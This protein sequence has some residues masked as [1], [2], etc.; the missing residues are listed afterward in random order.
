[1]DKLFDTD[2]DL[3]DLSIRS[4]WSSLMNSKDEALIANLVDRV[5][6]TFTSAFSTSNIPLLSRCILLLN[7]YFLHTIEPPFPPKLSFSTYSTF[8]SSLFQLLCTE[9]LYKSNPIIISQS[10]QLLSS[11]SSTHS[12]STELYPFLTLFSTSNVEMKAVPL[13]G[14]LSFLS[15]LKSFIIFINS[16]MEFNFDSTIPAII[17]SNFL[18][19]TDPRILVKLFSIIS[20][21]GK[22]FDCTPDHVTI[23]IFD[24]LI[25]FFPID[26]DPPRDITLQGITKTFMNNELFLA[27][28]KSSNMGVLAFSYCIELF[29]L[30]EECEEN[31]FKEAIVLLIKMAENSPIVYRD[32]VEK[33][34]NS[35]VDNSGLISSLYQSHTVKSVKICQSFINDLI[36]FLRNFESTITRILFSF[37]STTTRRL[38]E[39]VGLAISRQD[40]SNSGLALKTAEREAIL[41]ILSNICRNFQSDVVLSSCLD[42]IFRIVI[43]TLSGSSGYDLN[44]IPFST[45]NDCCYLLATVMKLVVE[46]SFELKNCAKILA[47]YLV[48]ILNLIDVVIMSAY[49]EVSGVSRLGRAST[50]GKGS[51]LS[52]IG[53]LI[54]IMSRHDELSVVELILCPKY[55][56]RL[57]S[58]S[59]LDENHVIKTTATSAL[60]LIGTDECCLNKSN[61]LRELLN[62]AFDDV[63]KVMTSSTATSSE[64]F[65]SNILICSCFSS[66]LTTSNLIELI[67]Y[68]SF[69]FNSEHG[70]LFVESLAIIYQLKNTTSFDLIF[71]HY[72]ET[73]LKL[74]QSSD[75][76]KALILSRNFWSN[77]NI[78]SQNFALSTEK[79]DSFLS[80]LLNDSIYS[81]R[82]RELT[83]CF[84]LLSFSLSKISQLSTFNYSTW[85]PI[86]FKYVTSSLDQYSEIMTIYSNNFEP[87]S[88]ETLQLITPLLALNSVII[89]VNNSEFVKF[90]EKFFTE[91]LAKIDF[92][93]MSVTQ[94][95]LFLSLSF[96][97][98]SISLRNDLTPSIRKD[99]K[100]FMSNLIKLLST[101]NCPGLLV[102]IIAFLGT[103]GG[104][105]FK[106]S[107][108]NSTSS[109]L[110][111]IIIDSGAQSKREIVLSACCLASFMVK[112]GVPTSLDSVKATKLITLLISNAFGSSNSPVP[113]DDLSVLL[114]SCT[115]SIISVLYSFEGV[116]LF[117]SKVLAQLIIKSCVQIMSLVVGNSNNLNSLLSRSSFLRIKFVDFFLFCVLKCSDGTLLNDHIK[118]VVQ[119]TGVLLDDSN[120]IVR[121]KAG[122]TRHLWSLFKHK[123]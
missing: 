14:R 77:P 103:N 97:L 117:I 98:Y 95:P 56:L 104:T 6:T 90:Y 80:S 16:L 67:K 60:C 1:M 19:E 24:F 101:E 105:I 96:S 84:E 63:Y 62:S 108:I 59:V 57:V 11:Y 54:F 23:S 102:S 64:S 65:K 50:V 33:D 113:A 10:F 38:F 94:I 9:S 18:S 76:E 92:S 2:I 72:F 30:Q 69:N 4:T 99:C 68:F 28:S 12:L 20:D 49:T 100:I 39:G 42:S 25:S 116:S 87:F 91:N 71:D 123:K 36:P 83:C 37:L 58:S 48:E 85:L 93:N 111:S 118:R 27:L 44:E 43:S 13:S 34:Q 47:K 119:A 51:V 31:L 3:L 32:Q 55:L 78:S 52:M 70:E 22:W 40:P 109:Q 120:A 110:I 115:L 122:Y 112:S 107:S 41:S 5:S 46:E 86:L 106:S 17:S 29:T 21:L 75:L 89:N 73:I 81:L 45:K 7:Q 8:F 121:N 88:D 82:S 26:Y 53:S 114:Q 15:F 61:I 79:I 66:L 74:L 35:V